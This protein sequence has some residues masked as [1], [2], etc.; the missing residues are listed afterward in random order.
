MRCMKAANTNNITLLEWIPVCWPTVQIM[1]SLLVQWL[2]FHCGHL[3]S[4]QNHKRK[5]SFT[6]AVLTD[7]QW[8]A[9]S[10]SSLWP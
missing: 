7:S 2:L 5:E 4:D 6:K 10:T 8:T 1:W 3:R 9:A